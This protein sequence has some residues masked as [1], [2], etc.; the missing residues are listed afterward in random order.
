MYHTG[1]RVNVSQFSCEIV[2]HMIDDYGA[3][4]KAL[5]DRRW[6]KIIEIVGQAQN[7]VE[8]QRPSLNAASMQQKR[9]ILYVA[10]SD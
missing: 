7:V 3:N 6:L 10:S 2:G 9:R 4:A 5:S 1:E 8:D